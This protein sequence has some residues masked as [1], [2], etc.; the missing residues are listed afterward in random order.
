MINIKFKNT[1]FTLIEI[2]IVI[3]IIAVLITLLMP[4]LLGARTRARDVRR[5]A[6]LSQIQKSLELYKQDQNPPSYPASNFLTTTLCNSCWSENL[7]S[8]AGNIYMRKVPCDP[9]FPA[10]SPY[11]FTIDTED[12]LLYSLSACLE[13]TRDPDQDQTS[14]AACTSVGKVSYSVHEP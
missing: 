14:L 10:P 13:N 5:K 4:N 9:Q 11:I 2:L 1:G 6:D 7:T 3:A 12:D 8:C